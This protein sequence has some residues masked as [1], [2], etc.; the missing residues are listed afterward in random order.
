ME[1]RHRKWRFTISSWGLQWSERRM[2][3]N[4]LIVENGQLILGVL[5]HI[6]FVNYKINFKKYKS[7]KMVMDLVCKK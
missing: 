5:R 1:I 7:C 3:W 6:D 4:Q 2:K